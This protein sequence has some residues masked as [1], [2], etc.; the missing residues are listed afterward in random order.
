MVPR[1]VALFTTRP[2]QLALIIKLTLFTRHPIYKS[3]YLLALLIFSEVTLD[4]HI[5]C[6]KD[7]FSVN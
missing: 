3:P 2:V 5:E 1:E 4:G 7:S 6:D